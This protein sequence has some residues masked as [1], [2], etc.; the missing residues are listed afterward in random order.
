MPNQTGPPR[1]TR[2]KPN[3]NGRLL[4]RDECLQFINNNRGNRKL[5]LLLPSEQAE[6]NLEDCQD[7]LNR[8]MDEWHAET[9]TAWDDAT[10]IKPWQFFGILGVSFSCIMMPWLFHGKWLPNE[11]MGEPAR[12]FYLGCCFLVLA[13]VFYLQRHARR[14]DTPLAKLASSCVTI[15]GAGVGAFILS[16]SAF[17]PVSPWHEPSSFNLR[18]GAMGCFLMVAMAIEFKPKIAPIFEIL[19]YVLCVSGA[20]AVAL[21][22]MQFGDPDPVIRIAGLLAII[23]LGAF[24]AAMVWGRPYLRYIAAFLIIAAATSVYRKEGD[25]VTIT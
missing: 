19:T 2:P 11:N 21:T 7:L 13:I 24:F 3:D 12:L 16:L 6:L 18:L 20:L 1:I 4:S 14:T 9:M 5:P 25:A 17:H 23:L 10:R 8:E 22:D 15:V